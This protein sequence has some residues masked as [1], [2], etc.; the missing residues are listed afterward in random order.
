MNDKI[1]SKIVLPVISWMVLSRSNFQKLMFWTLSPSLWVTSFWVLLA[2]VLVA[3]IS[4]LASSRVLGS[5]LS[6]KCKISRSEFINNPFRQK[7]YK[8]C[9]KLIF[10][11]L[12]N[13]DSTI[14][15]SQFYL[16]VEFS[17]VNCQSKP[18]YYIFKLVNLTIR[19][20]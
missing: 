12:L 11:I 8:S 15:V 2:R 16:L 20:N 5:M 4:S 1:H 19:N 3:W 9:R 14:S 7:F 6:S 13:W 17:L 10:I 18:R